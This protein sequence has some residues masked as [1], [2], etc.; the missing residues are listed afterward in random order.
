MYHQ[1]KRNPPLSGRGQLFPATKR[2]QTL[3]KTHPFYPDGES[4]LVFTS[5]ITSFSFS[6][7]QPH[8][9]CCC[10]RFCQGACPRCW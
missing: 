4:P 6:E 2:T 8:H 5:K 7:R 3:R 9:D 1:T 10:E